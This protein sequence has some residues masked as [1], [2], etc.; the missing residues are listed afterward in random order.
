MTV[1]LNLACILGLVIG[2]LLLNEGAKLITDSAAAVSK[3]TG[4]SRFVI[5]ILVVSVLVALPEILI[6]L[7][8]L[9]EGSYHIAMG[10]ALGSHIVNI[11]LI[12]GLSAIIV[13][14]VATHEMVLR[15]AIFLLIIT[16]VS[17]ALILDKDLT[18]LEGIVLILLFLPY[19]INLATAPRTVSKKEIRE[20][21]KE[22]RI[23][24]ELVG[25]LFGQKITVRAGKLWLI[26]G[27]GLAVASAELVVISAIEITEIFAIKEW[28]MGITVIAIGSSM[29]DIM[30]AYHATKKG[31]ADLALAIGIGASIFTMLLTLGLMGLL[32]PGDVDVSIMEP[33]IFGMNIVVFALLI[34]MATRLI[35]RIDGIILLSIYIASVLVSIIVVI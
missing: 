30:A 35:N 31:Y 11:S 4:R 29:P 28:L 5:G 6:S 18:R 10:N 33:V 32:Y 23:E 8:A 2:F 1:V 34:F 20:T 22:I 7:F 27:I 3:K 15:D 24:L 12:I 19:A 14:L 16:L 26:L 21:V 13:P 25:Q 9:R 17:T